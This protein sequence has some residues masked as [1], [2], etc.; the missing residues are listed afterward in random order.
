MYGV[1]ENPAFYGEI[2]GFLG[3]DPGAVVEAAEGGVRVLF[4]KWDA[5]K[6]ERVVGTERVGNMLR[7][8]GGDTFT[9]V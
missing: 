4:S 3:L 9:F 5:L 1:P 2:V 6:L 8:R 7:E